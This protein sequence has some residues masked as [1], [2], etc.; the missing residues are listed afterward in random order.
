MLHIWYLLVNEEGI[1]SVFSIS[2]KSS[3]RVR[4]WNCDKIVI[5]LVIELCNDQQQYSTS[6]L[7]ILYLF[8]FIIPNDAMSSKLYTPTIKLSLL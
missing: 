3:E 2:A 1:A 8:F 6:I 5:E 7:T 4:P